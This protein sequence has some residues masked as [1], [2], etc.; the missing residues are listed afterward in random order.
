MTVERILSYVGTLGIGSILGIILKYIFD[1]NINRR[2]LLFEARTKAYAGITGRVLNLFLEPDI[3]I[4]K[5]E[6][7]IFAKINSLL[8]EACLLGS[9]KLVDLLGE[10]K[11]KVNEFHVVLAKKDDEKAK[12]LHPELVNLAV[13]V[14][15][16]MREDLFITSK[17]MWNW[18]RV[19]RK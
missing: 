17:S 19:K 16:Q 13:K 2:K 3:T 4:L 6:A 15:E 18:C 12:K 9:P 1:Y 10:F 11:V 5:N 8:S 7:L 14:G